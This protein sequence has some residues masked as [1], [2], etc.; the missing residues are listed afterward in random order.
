MKNGKFK[1]K[2]L[3][4]GSLSLE[5]SSNVLWKRLSFSTLLIMDEDDEVPISVG[6]RLCPPGPGPGHNITNVCVQVREKQ[7]ISLPLTNIFD[8]M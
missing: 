5:K 2:E 6:V 7:E 4:F 8:L 3:C 1:M